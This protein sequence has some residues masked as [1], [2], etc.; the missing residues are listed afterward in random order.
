MNL[1]EA[2]HQLPIGRKSKQL[3][4]LFT[5]IE[6][7]LVA[8]IS[9]REILEMLNSNGLE[10]TE[11]TYKSYLYRERKRRRSSGQP[12]LQRPARRQSMVQTSEPADTGTAQ[13]Q[14]L[15]ATRPRTFDFDP[16]GIPD[17]LK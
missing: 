2:L 5:S 4:S 10:L 15:T 17:L 16:S 12:G 13:S 3:R 14:D 6:K 11:R 9:H 7:K 8:G 1:E